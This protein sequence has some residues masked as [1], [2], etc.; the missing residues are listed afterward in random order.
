MMNS[1]KEEVRLKASSYLK[2]IQ[3]ISKELTKLNEF[4]IN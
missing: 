2:E 1:T 3:E 4:F